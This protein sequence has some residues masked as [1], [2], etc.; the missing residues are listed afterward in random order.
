MD[1]EIKADSVGNQGGQEGL[2]TATSWRQE[3]K[4]TVQWESWSV[5]QLELRIAR[6]Q[7]SATYQSKTRKRAKRTPWTKRTS[8]TE[9][10]KI[11]TRASRAKRATGTQI[12]KR[13]Q[14]TKRTEITE[15]AQITER[16]KRAKGAAREQR[17]AER[18]QGQQRQQRQQGRTQGR[19]LPWQQEQ[20]RR[21]A[22]SGEGRAE[23]GRLPHPLI[24]CAH[25]WANRTHCDPY[26]ITI[27]LA[28][29][30]FTYHYLKSSFLFNALAVS[31]ISFMIITFHSLSL[32]K[33]IMNNCAWS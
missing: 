22:H 28:C 6:I 14:I 4:E 7:R 13:A 27:I 15:G 12:T 31:P 17:R 9:R 3:T 21:Q 18:A 30:S 20:G 10:T 11:T 29:K 25:H 32:A 8:W 2:R 24:P 5:N 16:T 23:P 1:Q 19:Q 26:Y 33:F